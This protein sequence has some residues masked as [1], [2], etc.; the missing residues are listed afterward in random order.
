MVRQG[1]A[2]RCRLQRA[3][4]ARDVAVGRELVRN[5]GL[6]GG[7]E[8]KGG[9]SRPQPE[10]LGLVL[11]GACGGHRWSVR[12]FLRRLVRNFTTCFGSKSCRNRLF[13]PACAPGGQ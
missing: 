10:R 1:A 9:A 3:S 12:R 4:D 8:Q 6:A 11:G 7:G 13:P 5:G 2:R